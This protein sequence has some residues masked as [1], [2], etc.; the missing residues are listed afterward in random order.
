M[1]QVKF[2]WRV[3]AFPFDSSRRTTFVNQITETLRKIDGKFDSFWVADHFIPWASVVDDNVDTLECW[4]TMCYLAAA[5]PN[6][7]VGS[8]VMS[9]SYRNPAYLAK[10]AATLQLLSGGR[11]IFGIG[12]GWKDDEYRAYNYPFPSAATRIRQLDETVQIVRKMW[13]EFPASF[14]GKHYQISD[15]YCEPRPDPMPPVMIG[16]GGEQLTLRVVAQQADWWNLGG[17]AKDYAHKL[18]VLR[19]HCDAV[20]RDFDSIVKTTAQEGILLAESEADARR[21]AKS[22]PLSLSMGADAWTA[23]RAVEYLQQFVDLGVE[24][25]IL[26]FADFP[27]TTGIEIFAEQVIPQFR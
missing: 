7:D 19:G 2:G 14:S 23:D 5:F 20:G 15:A 12:A 3:P 26:R 10:A 17:T 24:H 1:A 9:Q 27:S 11:L 16:G 6:F 18:D 22:S 13:T 25:F 4:T 8:I 21:I